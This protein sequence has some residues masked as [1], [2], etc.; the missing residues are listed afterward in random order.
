MKE[1]NTGSRAKQAGKMGK[2]RV[3]PINKHSRRFIATSV[4]E[5]GVLAAVEKL[6]DF[7]EEDVLELVGVDRYQRGDKRTASR[8]GSTMG[9]LPLGGQK[10]KV[11]RPRV[12]MDGK[13]VTLPTYAHFSA[14]EQLDER[15]LRQV[16]AGV[17]SRRYKSSLETD[18]I[19]DDTFGASKSAM[20]RRF[21]AITAK[22]LDEWLARRLDGEEYLVVMIDGINL[23]ESVVIAA[24]GIS[25]DGYKRVLGT[26]EGAT[27]NAVVCQMLLNDL[28]QRGLDPTVSR[29]FVLDGAKAL[30]KAVHDTFG[31]RA[32]VQRCQIHKIRNVKQHL[33]KELHASVEQSMRQAY[34]SSELK[35]AEKLLLNVA[36]SLK[37][38][39]PRAA[40]SLAE[41][42]AETLTVVAMDLPAGLR[43]LLASTNINENINSTLRSATGNVKRWRDGR[44]V[45][46]WVA[47]GFIYAE[48]HLRRLYGHSNLLVLRDRL[49]ANDQELDKDKKVAAA[50]TA[51]KKAAA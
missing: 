21:V 17:A 19:S 2:G 31:K 39:H 6:A 29:L 28:V 45:M 40:N 46:R 23:G 25:V 27:E 26:W 9:Q 36:N 15:A 4:L 32:K 50:A 35:T 10:L 43:R 3:T 47:T 49:R 14:K 37:D 38:G 13:E 12:R 5:L 34:K 33:P 7:F 16:V 51:V 42:L 24:L 11:M 48:R 41:G 8:Y 30:H 22:R 20:N 18:G 1:D 44:M